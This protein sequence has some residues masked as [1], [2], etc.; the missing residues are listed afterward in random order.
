[1]PERRRPNPLAAVVAVA[2]VALGFLSVAFVNADLASSIGGNVAAPGPPTPAAPVPPE[3]FIPILVALGALCVLGLTWRTARTIRGL[4]TI[5]A[6]TI[7]AVEVMAAVRGV[8]PYLDP[9]A[10]LGPSLVA[11]L[12]ALAATAIGA[13]F[14]TEPRGVSNRA[15]WL[16]AGV[17]IV[18]LGA[19]AGAGAW[20]VALASTAPSGSLGEAG[21]PAA[22]DTAGLRLTARLSL[23]ILAGAAVLGSVLDAWP[24][25]RRAWGRSAAGSPT[26]VPL[27]HDLRRFGV[28]LA[29]E[30][31]PWRVAAEAERRRAVEDER[32]RLAAELHARVLPDLRLAA[33]AAATSGVPEPVAIRLSHAV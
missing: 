15:R 6:V 22:L 32:V 17:A 20:A 14:V 12:A 4:A 10:R 33:A 8:L 29:D 3:R 5:L 13:A 24:A 1:M 26:A 9:E 11:V 25:A 23:A 16:V 27:R 28:L 7:G 30:L 19:V 31:L 2:L 21:Q 18:G